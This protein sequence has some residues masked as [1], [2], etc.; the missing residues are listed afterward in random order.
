MKIF[1]Y[2]GKAVTVSNG[3]FTLMWL[4]PPSKTCMQKSKRLSYV[5]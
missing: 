3:I 4:V 5:T 2:P 1:L